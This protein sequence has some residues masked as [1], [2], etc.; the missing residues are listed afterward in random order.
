MTDVTRV[1][2]I[3]NP[4]NS[5]LYIKNKENGLFGDTIIYI[6]R[7]FNTHLSN[8]QIEK[9]KTV[10]EKTTRISGCCGI[11]EH[12][13]WNG[14]YSQ[15]KINDLIKYKEYIEGLSYKGMSKLMQ[16]VLAGGTQIKTYEKAILE[17]GFKL[18]YDF[19]N[20][21][22]NQCKVYHMLVSTKG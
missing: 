20:T 8:N 13:N 11:I 17:L 5:G 1:R 3:Y 10:F 14:T 6:T 9:L 18:D 12:H 7:E 16:V 2:E 22:G 15:S 21:S 4:T 19:V